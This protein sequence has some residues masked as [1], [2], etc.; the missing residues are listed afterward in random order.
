[1]ELLSNVVVLSIE[2]MSCARAIVSVPPFT[3][4]ELPP[5]PPDDPEP[6]PHAVSAT[7]ATAATP[8]NL[9]R[10]DRVIDASSFG[11]LGTGGCVL[12]RVPATSGAPAGQAR[13]D[14]SVHYNKGEVPGL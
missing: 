4:E 2:M 14:R 12:R 5:P 7:A 6:L 8:S 9:T 11:P 3:G 10:V 1:M 13:R